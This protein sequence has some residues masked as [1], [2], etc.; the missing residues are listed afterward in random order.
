[1]KDSYSLD[2]D[3]AG[4]DRAFQHHFDAYRRIFER[5]GLE[6]LAVEASSGAMGGSESIEFMVASDA[7]EDWVASCGACGYAANVEKATSQLA[8]VADGPRPRGARE[9]RDA[10]RAHD[11]GSRALRGRRAGRAPDQDARLRARRRRPRW[12]CCAAT[13]RSR[14]RSCATAPARVQARPA[15]PEEI[16]AALGAVAGQPRRGRRA[17][18]RDPRRR[19]ARRPRGMTTGANQDDFHLRGVDVARDIRVDA[20]LDLREV[21][22]RRGLP[23][24]RRARSASR[25]TIEVGH[26]FKLGTR[27]SEAMGALR[28][29]RG[30]QV[31]ARSDGLLRHRHRAHRG[32][33]R[34]GAPRRERHRLAGRRSRRSRS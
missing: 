2:L 9:V 10:G 14:S 12:C 11:R 21:A 26:I 17:R 24:V 15:Q 30:G 3:R 33:G 5:C 20:W 32:R 23:G 27:Y 22:R 29:G 7:G 1:M 18:A 25:K 19:G 6:T 31:R 13:T 28:A 34:R 4:L 8:A 16:R